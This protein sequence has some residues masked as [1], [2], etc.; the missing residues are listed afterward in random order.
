MYK[1]QNNTK[2]TSLW[3]MENVNNT[4]NK[5]QDKKTRTKRSTK[6]HK[7]TQY[8]RHIGR[9]AEWSLVTSYSVS[10]MHNMNAWLFFTSRNIFVQI[11]LIFHHLYAS[12]KSLF[13]WR[14]VQRRENTSSNTRGIM[15][16]FV[17][18][19]WGIFLFPE[20]FYRLIGVK[21]NNLNHTH[22]HRMG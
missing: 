4:F 18:S 9:C 17:N 16:F 5:L 6:K 3:Y 10:N 14:R 12:W 19:P 22:G 8:R 15:K 20:F 1:T 2:L 13:L 7:T 11:I 21:M